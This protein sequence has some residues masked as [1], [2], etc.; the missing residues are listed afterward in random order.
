MTEIESKA[1]KP[2]MGKA[3]QE[4]LNLILEYHLASTELQTCDH[5]GGKYRLTDYGISNLTGEVANVFTSPFKADAVCRECGDKVTLEMRLLEEAILGIATTLA[6][7]V[8]KKLNSRDPSFVERDII[9]RQARSLCRVWTSD[10]I[11]IKV[12]I[13]TR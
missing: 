2:E 13:P 4:I 7:R 6:S 10:K 5:C 8:F 11:E 1:D 9:D 12:S 3:Q